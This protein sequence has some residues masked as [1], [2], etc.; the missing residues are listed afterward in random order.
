MKLFLLGLLGIGAYG[1]YY[2][3]CKYETYA[4]VTAF[5]RAAQ[6]FRQLLLKKMITIRPE[7]VKTIVLDL[8]QKTGVEIP[9]D[10]IMVTIE[11]L[12]AANSSKLNTIAQAAMGIA[13]KMSNHR[14]PRWLVGFKAPV[15]AVHGVATHSIVATQYVWSDDAKP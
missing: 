6:D 4:K 3:F 8:A 15:K 13:R 2:G 9:A 12:T 10:K 7:H 1:G 11:P 14:T 5:S